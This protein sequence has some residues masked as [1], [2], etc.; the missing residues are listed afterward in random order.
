MLI[1]DHSNCRCSCCC[2]FSETESFFFFLKR[3]IISRCCSWRRC[4]QRINS[5]AGGRITCEIKEQQREELGNERVK[6][7]NKRYLKFPDMEQHFEGIDAGFGSCFSVIIF[8]PSF[9]L[10]KNYFLSFK[11][12]LWESCVISRL[13]W[14]FL[15]ICLFSLLSKLQSWSM[16]DSSCHAWVKIQASLLKPQP[17]VCCLVLCCL[18]K[19]L[20]ERKPKFPVI[21]AYS[22]EDDDD[23]SRGKLKSTWSRSAL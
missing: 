15:I 23:S 9:L 4:L 18:R 1:L 19:S 22:R 16:N 7:D 10:V 17:T 8:R 3:M 14:Y 2:G 21:I 20:K 5:A 11:L 6:D 13:S 12:F